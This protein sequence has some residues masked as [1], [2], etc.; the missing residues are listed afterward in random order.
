MNLHRA[1]PMRSDI[2][3][4][5]E[6]SRQRGPVRNRKDRK[7]VAAFKAYT[8]IS[9]VYFTWRSAKLLAALATLGWART[10]RRM[11]RS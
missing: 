9:V 6:D 10:P 7:A 11:K 2:T 3:V 5:E 8:G 1:N 4:V